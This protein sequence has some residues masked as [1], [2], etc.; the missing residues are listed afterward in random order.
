MFIHFR[1]AALVLLAVVASLGAATAREPAPPALASQHMAATANPMASEA[2]RAILRAG[3]SAVDA[4]IAA[5][6]VLGVVEPQASGIG[7]G[8]FLLHYDARSRR[9]TAWDGRE[10]APAGATERLFLDAEGKPLGFRDAVVSGL[11]IGVP[12]TV[13]MLEAAHRRHG[14][15]PWADL[16]VPAIGLA[17]NGFAMPPRLAAALRAWPH[18]R[19]D[20]QAR[21]IFFAED[22]SPGTQGSIVRNP[23][24]AATM[25]LIAGRGADG[26]HTGPLADAIA[27]TVRRQPRPGT[28]TTGDLAGY[29][30]LARDPLCRPWREWTVCGMGPPSSGPLAILQALAML[31]AGSGIGDDP[32]VDA[33]TTRRPT[34]R[35]ALAIA[36]AHWLAE[37]GRLIF[38][39]RGRYLGDPGFVAVPVDGL[40]D[41]AYIADRTSLVRKDRALGKAEPGLPPGA[42]GGNA[43]DGTVKPERGTSHLSIVDRDGNVVSFTTTIEGPFGAGHFAG[44]FPLNNEL[45][46]FDFTP[47]V[48][49]RPLANRV[50]AG[51]RPRSSMSPLIVLDREGRFVL[52]IGS[53][54]GARIVGNVLQATLAALAGNLPIQRAID[55]RRVLNRNGV[56]EI[57]GGPDDAE[58][59]TL[60]AALGKLGPATTT[61]PHAGGLH[62]VRARRAAD[63]T[64]LGYEGGADRRRDGAALG[65]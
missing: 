58:S 30:P 51:K 49:G 7:G 23:Q 27:D 13:R 25:R 35:P 39:D 54:G 36:D 47:S 57:E 38:A 8:G 33:Q 16:F 59:L 34:S 45:T 17:E 9:V 65:D 26:L 22:G 55:Q 21:A 42:P 1:R 31:P 64:L 37:T 40:L 46:D 43:G 44:G 24:L 3:G 6:M 5:Q 60:A 14:K 15:L 41:P 10:T 28:L 32:A 62:G 12:G 52:A 53:A 56:T 11:S 2:A 4:A 48:D 50:Q 20:E 63:G 18:V 29:R 19:A 61:A